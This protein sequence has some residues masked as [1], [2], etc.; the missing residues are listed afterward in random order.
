MPLLE[1]RN[2]TK[3]F[4]F[5]TQT[6][7][8]VLEHITMAVDK[9]DFVCIV[10]PSGCGK[11][12]LLRIICG[13]IPPTDGQVLFK[14]SEVTQVSDEMAMVFQSFALFPWLT[15]LENVEIGLYSKKMSREEK[16]RRALKMIEMIGLKG[17]E[18][19]Y[20]RELSGGMKQRVG[21]ARALVSEPTVL[22]MDEPFSSLDP[23][24]ATH[25]REELVDFWLNPNM[26]PDTVIM[27]T[28]SVEEAVY[29]ANRVI[30][31]SHRPGTIIKEVPVDL[32]RPRDPRSD[33]LYALVDQITSLIA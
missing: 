10:G 5:K 3:S 8:V 14:G 33:K 31:L 30:V 25:L 2:V 20:P 6:P 22:L 11:S 7:F 17:F 18:E 16:R 29:L 26:A 28:H 32:P 1:L 15:I 4:A 13:L 24:T 9:G 27:V 12:T 23:L 19:A 21:L